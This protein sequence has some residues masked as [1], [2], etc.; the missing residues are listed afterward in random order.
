MDMML[1]LGILAAVFLVSLT[2]IALYHDTL[3]LRVFN[4]MFLIVDV[5]FYFV[6][7]IGM[8]ERGWL[9]DGFETFEN[10]SPFIF[11]IIPL[12]CL[13]SER[14]KQY[15]Y[16]AI[17]LLW[18]GMFVALFISPEQAYLVSFYTEATV[19]YTGEA[20]CH[21]WAALFGL[22]LIVTKQVELSFRTWLR[23]ITFMYTV[24][25]F[26]V[27]L[28]FCFHTS[29]FG[30]DPYGDY[31][32]YFIDIFGTFET[33][34]IAYLLGVLTVLNIGFGTGFLFERMLHS[35][36]ERM[37]LR[38]LDGQEQEIELLDDAFVSTA[39]QEGKGEK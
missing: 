16:S 9:A 20:L 33:T 28:N 38:K 19:L 18:A 15:A 32:I 35:K 17:A 23:A 1:V 4:A 39:Q 8:Y 7:N 26:G 30:M 36:Q 22:Y 12:T 29:F 6:W 13:M 27:L 10:I 3:N 11:T 25:G 21:M 14:V 34:L 24:I 2:L 31:G 5:I 37:V